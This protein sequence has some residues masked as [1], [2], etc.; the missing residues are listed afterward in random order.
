MPLHNTGVRAALAAA[1]LAW[2]GALVLYIRTLAPDV[3]VGDSGEFQFTGAILGIPH[4]TGYPLY[5]LLGKVWSL[6]P[7]GTVAYRINLSSAVYLAAAI[8]ILTA[9]AWRL[10]GLLAPSA[11]TAL[12]AAPGGVQAGWPGAA[13]AGAALLGAAL[14]AVAATVWA[15][16]VVARSYALNALLV[17]ACLAALLLWWERGARG[18]FLAAALAVGLS[19]AHH[20]TTVTL[21]PGYALIALLAEWRWRGRERLPA[22]LRRLAAGAAMGLLGLSPYLLFAYRFVFGYTYYWGNPATW[23]DVLALARGAPFAGQVFAYPFTLD[24]QLARAGFGLDQIAQQFGL[25]G[26]GLGLAGLARLLIDRG[27]RPFAAGLALLWLGNFAFA[28]NY[29][30]IGHIYLIPTYLFWGV[31]LAAALTWPFGLI[32]RL[33]W[34]RLRRVLGASALAGLAAAALLLPAGLALARFAHEDRSGDTRI[35][36]LAATTLAGVAP[37]AHVLVDWESICVL[38][39]YRYVDGRRLDL[40]LESGDPDHW[41]QAIGQDLAAGRPVYVG[42]FAG[43]DPPL[44]VRRAYRLQRL[45]LVYQVLGPVG[46]TTPP[47]GAGAARPPGNGSPI[48]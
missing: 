6:L 3:L 2:A 42:G 22:R 9:V 44:A 14:V 40:N 17:T 37:G 45:G 28:V 34:R 10:L 31:F 23:S 38:R 13:R 35:R 12:P 33:P 47:A 20:G 29:G 26:L 16:A 15:Q 43:P 21:L 46:V 19:L 30:I 41:D 48:R 7:L 32:A 4:P 27:T 24:S 1:L 39:Y 36:D 8:G 18:A 5:T 11:D 25:L